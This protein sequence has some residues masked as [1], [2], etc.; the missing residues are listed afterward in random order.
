MCKLSYQQLRPVVASMIDDTPA[1]TKAHLTLI[2]K[3][4][5]EP[6][7]GEGY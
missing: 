4:K 6:D 2:A 7:D 5:K 3:F 1:T